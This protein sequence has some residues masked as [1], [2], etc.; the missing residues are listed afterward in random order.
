MAAKT[1]SSAEVWLIGKGTKELS[2]SHLPT[3][4]DVL[5]LMMFYHVEEKSPLK[6]AAASAV[7]KVTEVWE[8]AR[9]PCQRIDSCIRIA[10]KV[11]EEYEKLKKNRKRNN[12]GDL[13]N[14]GMFKSH[15]VKLYDIAT[16]DALITMKNEEDR[17]F[18]I[19]Q[20]NDV[21]SCSMSGVDVKLARKEERKDAR[22]KRFCAFAAK[23]SAVDSVKTLNSSASVSVSNSVPST[24]DCRES[25]SSSSQSSDS[26]EEFQNCKLT[27]K[28][29]KSQ[30]KQAKV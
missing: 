29:N 2:A 26:V 12:E 21:L 8:R 19:K 25:S 22:E 6:A 23:V 4:G 9:I 18:L 5:R 20:R 13:S 7:S 15:L 14:Q 17:Q 30:P 10:M 24:V 16:S 11:Y 28:P 27:V 3:N 1:R